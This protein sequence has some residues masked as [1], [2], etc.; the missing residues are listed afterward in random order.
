MSAFRW[1]NGGCGRSERRGER[2]SGP[3]GDVRHAR[4]GAE[5]VD[6]PVRLDRYGW[7]GMAGSVRAGSRYGDVRV[8]LK[9]GARVEV[10]PVDP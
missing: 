8:R 4:A 5:P 1:S 7:I 3:A 9:E 2:G 6:G 10:R